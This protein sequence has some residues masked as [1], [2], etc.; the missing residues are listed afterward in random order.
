MS[1]V[2]VDVG[3]TRVKWGFCR[4]GHVVAQASLPPDDP[5]AWQAQRNAW[6]AD[7]VRWILAGVHPLRSDTFAS[8]ARSFGDVVETIDSHRQLPLQVQ[9]DFPDKVGMDRLLNAVAANA[10]RR[11][12]HAAILVDAGSAVTVDLVDAAGVFRGGTI[13]PGLRLMAQSLHDYTAKLPVVD[14]RQPFAPPGKSTETAIQAGVYHAV[15]GG[16]ERIVAELESFVGATCVIY[17][18]GGDAELLSQ[19]TM[20]FILCPEM[21]L[22]GIL[23]SATK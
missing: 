5:A 12:G 19:R 10:R 23:L 22:E 20:P 3:N 17:F 4:A 2:V 18:T 1:L 15:I 11:A 16:I 6:G 9:V 21:T 14:I 8:W 13:F 7:P